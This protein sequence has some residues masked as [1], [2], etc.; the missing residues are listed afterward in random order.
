MLAKAFRALFGVD[1]DAVFPG[2]AAAENAV[3]GGA[4]FIGELEGL[5][6]DRVRDAGGEIDEGLVRGRSGEAEVIE[7]LG[8]RV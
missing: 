3:V 2:G 5:D 1:G 4:G 6:E 8:L 7:R